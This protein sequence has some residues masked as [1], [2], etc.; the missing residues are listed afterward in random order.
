MNHDLLKQYGLV[1]LEVMKC[2][3][4]RYFGDDTTTGDVPVSD[5]VNIADIMPSTDNAHKRIFYK[6]VQSNMIATAIKNNL[7][8]ESWRH[9]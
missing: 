3:V 1:S 4:H 6:R 7:T 9:L 5:A 2:Y 8:L